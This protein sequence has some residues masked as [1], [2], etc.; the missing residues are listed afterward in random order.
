M[1]RCLKSEIPETPDLYDFVFV[2]DLQVEYSQ[3]L[4]E[5]QI[6]TTAEK[7]L[8]DLLPDFLIEIDLN[9][10]YNLYHLLT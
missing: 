3:F 5:Y 8:S 9:R 1:V 4:L 7:L 10:F 2:E 6:R